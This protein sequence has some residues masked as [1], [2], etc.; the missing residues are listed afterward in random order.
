[1]RRALTMLEAAGA[2]VEATSGVYRTA[3]QE[4][5]DQPDF[6]NA[7][8][9]IGFDGTP[10]E[11]LV[12]LKRIESDLGRTAGRRYGPRAIDLDIVAWSDGAWHEPGLDVP[13][14]R[15]TARRFVL[16]PLCDL[17]PGLD[18]AGATA[19]EHAERC[20]A[21]PDQAVERLHAV[22]LR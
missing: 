4:R 7:V 2:R 22:T 21:D 16:V 18:L 14:P 11:L 1:M 17:D 12:V 6:T 3:P 5:T 10:P 20:A 15:A 13:H 19:R 9:R 8:A